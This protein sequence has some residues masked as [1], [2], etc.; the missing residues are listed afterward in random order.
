MENALTKD[1]L[2]TL[3]ELL[4]STFNSILRIEE[5]SLNNRLTEGLSIAELHTICAVGLHEANPMKVIANRLGITL[6]TLTVMINKLEKRSYVKRERSETDRRASARC[7]YREG[8]QSYARSRCFSQEDGGKRSCRS[9][10]GRRRGIRK[11]SWK[12]E[13]LFR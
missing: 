6:A 10:P 9:Y 13:S 5:R 8:A 7:A 11:S 3:D 12:G 4:S 2:K 1:D